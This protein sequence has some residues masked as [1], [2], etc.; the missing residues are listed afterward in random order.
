MK[1]CRICNRAFAP[2]PELPNK[3]TCSAHCAVIYSRR[4]YPGMPGK[5]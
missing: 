2:P 3:K 1:K 4:G 5:R